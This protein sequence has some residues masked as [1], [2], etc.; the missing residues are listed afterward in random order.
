MK[1]FLLQIGYLFEK[2]CLIIGKEKIQRKVPHR[3][4]EGQKEGK[5]PEKSPS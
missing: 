3:G 5:D 4:S 1:K 2:I